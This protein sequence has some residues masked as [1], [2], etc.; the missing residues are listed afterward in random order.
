MPD[1]NSTFLPPSAAIA[2]GETG[3]GLYGSPVA[4]EDTVPGAAGVILGFTYSGLPVVLAVT[5]LEWLDDLEA[6]VRL[7]RARGI[8]SAGMTAMVTA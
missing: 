2:I 3:S 7:A 6:A 8:I 5:S 4:A 1:D